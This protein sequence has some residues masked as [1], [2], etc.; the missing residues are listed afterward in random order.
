MVLEK[1][2]PSRN[3]ALRPEQKF[4]AL[5]KDIVSKLSKPG[6]LVVDPSSGTF[7]TV[8]TFVMLRR[9][10][11]LAEYAI[12]EKCYKRSYHSA[13]NTISRQVLDED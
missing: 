6:R 4:V 3:H 8:K 5:L 7:A 13:V 11:R 10:R 9:H 1:E 2:D 12:E